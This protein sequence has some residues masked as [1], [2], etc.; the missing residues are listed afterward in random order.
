MYFNI[1]ICRAGHYGWGAATMTFTILPFL[2]AVFI[3]FISPEKMK[4]AK[5][6]DNDPWYE[7]WLR[8]AETM[9]KPLRY[10][11]GFQTAYHVCVVVRMGQYTFE[12]SDAKSLLEVLGTKIE[13]DSI[14]AIPEY[15][16][17]DQST[18]DTFRKELGEHFESYLV[19]ENNS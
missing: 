16:N 15:F 1:I 3:H 18:Y 9:P 12:I 13:T 2:V 11:P 10:I 4:F 6:T 19:A 14:K 5:E 17:Y 8:K 7:T